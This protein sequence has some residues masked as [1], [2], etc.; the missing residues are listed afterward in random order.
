MIHVETFTRQDPEFIS[1]TYGLTK[2]TTYDGSQTST[3]GSVS[4]PSTSI[5]EKTT[6]IHAVSTMEQKNEE[7]V[8][9]KSVVGDIRW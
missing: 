7:N 5:S 9:Q 3:I 8:L 2:N 1:S 6:T 4:D